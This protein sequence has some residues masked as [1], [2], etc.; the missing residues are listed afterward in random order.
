MIDN[1]NAPL[2]RLNSFPSTRL[3][4]R[5]ANVIARAMNPSAPASWADSAWIASA[6]VISRSTLGGV[7]V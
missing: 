2:R 1:V 5:V 3:C 7:G 6:S 4:G